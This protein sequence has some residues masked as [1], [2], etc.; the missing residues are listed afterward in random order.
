MYTAKYIRSLVMGSRWY[1]PIAAA[2]LIAACYY[3]T[4]ALTIRR[5]A[6]AQT[7]PVAFVLQ[8]ESYSYKIEPAGRLL[9]RKTV[10]RRPDGNTARIT[11]F[12]YP[13]DRTVRVLDHMNGDS[14]TIVDD[15]G[16]KTTW[17]PLY[18]GQALKARNA[19]ILHPPE[20][21]AR[22]SDQ[23][24]GYSTVLGHRVTVVKWPASA[25]DQ[26]T[27]WLA[28]DLGCEPLRNRL[29]VRQP[30]GSFRRQSEELAVSLK[31]QLS[32]SAW[33]AERTDYKEVNPSELERLELERL[34]VPVP[35]QIRQQWPQADQRYSEMRRHLSDQP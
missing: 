11:E 12:T 3:T 21:C 19:W 24:V 22:A 20:N 34:Q 35:D 15:I 25:D 18:S 2:T 30:D 5:F 7:T 23:F 26:V 16:A 28:P 29:D 6:L 10:A 14:A 17:R 1:A 31:F 4:K 32:D 27:S 8:I 33:F 9:A 13:V